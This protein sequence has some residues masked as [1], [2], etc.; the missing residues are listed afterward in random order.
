MTA[1]S[2]LWSVGRG[3]CGEEAFDVELAESFYSDPESNKTQSGS[4]PSQEG[5]F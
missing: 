1:I 2:P 5:S 3:M 4:K